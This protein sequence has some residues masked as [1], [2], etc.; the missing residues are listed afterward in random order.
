L[1]EK[2]PDSNEPAESKVSLGGE[3]LQQA[4]AAALGKRGSPKNTA[5][6]FAT[7]VATRSSM[8]NT[9][10]APK[11]KTTRGTKNPV[12]AG[13]SSNEEEVDESGESI[14]G[15]TTEKTIMAP[16]GSLGI[17]ISNLSKSKGTMVSDV[18]TKS[19]LL[20]KVLP[21]DRIIAVDGE[22]VSLLTAAELSKIIASKKESEKKLTI[23]TPLNGGQ[24]SLIKDKKK[25]M[26]DRKMDQDATRETSK[27]QESMGP[28]K[29]TQ[30][31]AAAVIAANANKPAKKIKWVIYP[32]KSE[33]K[34]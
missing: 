33:V 4:I 31:A 9:D 21:G 6:D 15:Q 23:V 13:E 18:L 7:R 25:K 34:S 2:V 30:R 32:G 17:I 19:V 22:D 1:A 27:A 20:D 16:P 14:G 5:E 26:E 8:T 12:P 24:V 3:E 10:E 29:G 28:K 11:P